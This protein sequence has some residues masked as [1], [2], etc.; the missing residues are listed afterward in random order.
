MSKPLVLG[1][2]ETDPIEIGRRFGI[3]RRA[4]GYSMRGLARDLGTS[5]N[6]LSL[7]ERGERELSKMIALRMVALTDCSLDYLFFGR[8]SNLPDDLRGFIRAESA[9]RL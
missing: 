7:I 4:R 9:A 1:H 2:P 3:V 6:F 5:H 8:I